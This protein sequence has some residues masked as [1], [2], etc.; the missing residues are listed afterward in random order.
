MH[1]LLVEVE[2]LSLL[3]V[4][5]ALSVRLL[6]FPFPD[7]RQLRIELIISLLLIRNHC[8][9]NW[10]GGPHGGDLRRIMLVAY[11]KTLTTVA[12][13]HTGSHS[14]DLDTVTNLVLVQLERPI[15]MQ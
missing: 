12:A 10:R 4:R 1:R 9:P 2:L 3:R 8:L 6:F 13:Q 5:E 7:R 15:K 14:N 11:T